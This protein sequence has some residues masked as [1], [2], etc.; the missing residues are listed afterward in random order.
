MTLPHAGYLLGRNTIHVQE[1]RNILCTYEYLWPSEESTYKEVCFISQNCF[2]IFYTIFYFSYFFYKYFHS[3]DFAKF[4]FFSF[5]C[6]TF[7]IFFFLS[8][9]VSLFLQIR[10]NSEAM[11]KYENLGIVGEG[12]YGMVLKCKH[13]DTN[14]IVAIKKFLESEDDKLV[15]KIAFREIK[16]LKV[17]FFW[18]FFLY[19]HYSPP[20]P[21]PPLRVEKNLFLALFWKSF[22]C[23]WLIP[24]KMPHW[25]LNSFFIFQKFGGYDSLKIFKNVFSW[26]VLGPWISSCCFLTDGIPELL[27]CIF[28]W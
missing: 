23:K 28:W 19:L 13:K 2:F 15:K 11:D 3:S 24:P 8:F 7:A 21:T 18:V 6:L 27:A 14:Q 20:P 10:F 4:S 26:S 1:K 16:M 25:N 17:S 5:N 9:S 12:S 22:Q